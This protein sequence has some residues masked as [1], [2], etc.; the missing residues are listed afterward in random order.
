MYLFIFCRLSTNLLFLQKM[1]NNLI[2]G[3]KKRRKSDLDSPR[4]GPEGDSINNKEI[5]KIKKSKSPKSVKPISSD[6]E[7]I[8][9]TNILPNKK[10]RTSS[11]NNSDLHES[12]T[13]K[14]YKIENVYENQDI[15]NSNKRKVITPK[16]KAAQQKSNGSL[17]ASW[18]KAV[19][20]AR[21]LP[22]GATEGTEDSFF[23]YSDPNSP[24]K[25]KKD[26]SVEV[27]KEKTKTKKVSCIMNT[28]SKFT[29]RFQFFHFIYDP[30][31]LCQFEHVEQRKII[32]NIF[33]R[34]CL[35]QQEN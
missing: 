15:V 11:E 16:R 20:K 9:P 23:T 3:K 34:C 33:F 30:L 1:D 35:P 8:S 10:K 12:F 21:G 6:S 14:K 5:L 4:S 29:F 25:K 7:N 13:G 24:N 22:D 26:K 31:L 17:N 27:K 28:I 19:E 32:Q 18:E 2:S